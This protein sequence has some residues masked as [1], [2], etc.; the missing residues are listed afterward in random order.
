MHT[1]E[2]RIAHP[3]LT[4]KHIRPE[5]NPAF[6]PNLYKWMKRNAHF[7]QEGGTPATVWR[8]KPDAP[9]ANK[10]GQNTLFLGFPSGE[11]ATDT[12]FIGVKLMAALKDGGLKECWAYNHAD[13]LE[14]IPNFWETYLQVG[15]CA[16]DPE[17]RTHFS[18]QR[19][20]QKGDH[21]TCIWCGQHQQRTVQVVL[22]EEHIDHWN[23][24]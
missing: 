7:Y 12:T 14:A 1:Q 13:Q 21:R 11:H 6:S 20:N 10:F 16:I 18:D 24:A 9:I 3:T 22:R 19:F 8:I 2:L 23:P 4:A 17:H 5:L 15:R